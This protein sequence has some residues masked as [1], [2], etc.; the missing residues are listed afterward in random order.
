MLSSDLE[1]EKDFQ[2]PSVLNIQRSQYSHSH[3]RLQQTQLIQ[4]PKETPNHPDQNHNVFLPLL[5][6]ITV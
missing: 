2:Y 3:N 1:Y 6:S 5:S 4:A